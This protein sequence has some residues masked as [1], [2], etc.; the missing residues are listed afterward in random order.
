MTGREF[1]NKIGLIERYISDMNEFLTSDESPTIMKF[2]DDEILELRT[3]LNDY[4]KMLL[5]GELK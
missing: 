2:C 3:W 4:R 1:I 5:E